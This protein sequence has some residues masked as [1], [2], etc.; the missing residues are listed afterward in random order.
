MAEVRSILGGAL[1]AKD[2]LVWGAR[3]IGE[4]SNEQHRHQPQDDFILRWHT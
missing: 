3:R 4:V 2:V 1:S